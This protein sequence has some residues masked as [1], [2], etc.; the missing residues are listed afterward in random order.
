MK[1]FRCSIYSPKSRTTAAATLILLSLMLL[2]GLATACRSNNSSKI[3][4]FPIQIAPAPKDQPQLLFTLLQG[5]LVLENGCLQIYS[6]PII[7]RYGYSWLSEEN[8]VWVLND[9][10]EKVAKNGDYVKM[11][12]GAIAADSVRSITGD[13]P[14]KGITGQ[15]WLMSS[16]SQQ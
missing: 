10:H 11:G 2:L 3:T 6:M 1:I 13:E 14:P 15:F 4:Y 12:G 8:I 9:K 7:W 5:K 16:I